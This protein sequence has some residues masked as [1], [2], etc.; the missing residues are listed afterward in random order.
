MEKKLKQ[1]NMI[2]CI[3]NVSNP[4]HVGP[5]SNIAAFAVYPMQFSLFPL[6]LSN[7]LF[8]HLSQVLDFQN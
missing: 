8:T 3:Q 4:Y 1:R 5:A 2:Y 6:F 7:N